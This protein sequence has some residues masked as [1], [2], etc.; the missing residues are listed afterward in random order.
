LT[1]KPAKCFADIHR[2]LNIPLAYL[3]RSQIFDVVAELKQEEQRALDW[4]GPST[5]RFPG[6]LKTQ[7]MPARWPLRR[8]IRSLT[9]AAIGLDAGGWK[10]LSFTKQ[11]NKLLLEELT[12]QGRKDAHLALVGKIKERI[13]DGGNVKHQFNF[14]EFLAR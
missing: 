1:F 7:F 12:D 4:L 13:L 8:S 14:Q 2:S 11:S 6:L 5:F 10:V 3:S 9:F